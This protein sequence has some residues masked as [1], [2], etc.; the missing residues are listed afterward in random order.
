[1][2]AILYVF[3]ALAPAYTKAYSR[4]VVASYVS[5][6]LYSFHNF[7]NELKVPKIDPHYFER[8]NSKGIFHLS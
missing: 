3:P 8:V 2:E 4:E 1:M 6:F 5:E 7:F